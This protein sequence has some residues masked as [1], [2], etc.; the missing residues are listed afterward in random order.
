MPTDRSPPPS[1]SP[2]ADAP[3]LSPAAL[4]QRAL[5]TSAGG[6]G[7]ALLVVALNRSDRLAALTQQDR[8]RHVLGQV[9]RRVE[10]ILQPADRY[11]VASIDEIW[12]LLGGA[13]TRAVAELAARTLRESLSRPCVGTLEGTTQTLAHLRAAIGGVWFGADAAL[14]AMALLAAATENCRQAVSAEDQVQVTAP[15]ALRQEHD[16]AQLAVELEAALRTNALDVYFQPQVALASGRCVS[17]EALVRW[18]PADGRPVDPGLISQ[19]AEERGLVGQLTQFVLNNALR[20]QAMWAAQGIELG[21]SINLSSVTLSEE[22]YPLHV[23]QALQ[24]WGVE[25]RHLTLELTES[26]IVR[27]EHAARDFFD[28]V[29]AIGCRLALDDF[30]IGYTSFDYLRKFPVDELKI[31]QSFVRDAAGGRNDLRIAKSLV[32]VARAFEL[33]TVAEGIETV[34]VAHALR[35][36][37]C[38]LGQGYLYSRPV[39]AGEFE[40]WYRSF[41][42]RAD[43]AEPAL[44]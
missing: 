22:S 27:N 6:S 37:G 44:P 39:P 20:M 31:D 35:A 18:T 12:L 42:R 26:L 23:E 13:T 21:V 2:A 30:G 38:D 15:R 24:T 41:D 8:A 10:A 29:R 40:P 11:A 7:R 25:P 19:V 43:A 32:E 3:R 34:E 5:S 16:R 36:A 28:R 9:A 14:D 33:Q 17:T 4:L 1:G